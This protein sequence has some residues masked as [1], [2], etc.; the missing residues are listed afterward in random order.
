MKIIE[1]LD[2]V[3]D[4]QLGRAAVVINDVQ[5]ADATTLEFLDYLWAPG[6]ASQVSSGAPQPWRVH[7]AA[8]T[9][10]W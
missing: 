9:A 8:D 10:D 3:Q 5:W 7:P 6:H 2:R 4:P 1:P